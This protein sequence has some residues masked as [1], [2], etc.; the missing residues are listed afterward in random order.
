MKSFLAQGIIALLVC[1]GA[2]IGFWVWY[3]MIEAKS[4]SVAALEQQIQQD[5]DT[6]SRV[7]AARASLAE[8][9]QDEA[10]IRSYFISEVDV[11]SFNDALETQRHAPGATVKVVSVSRGGPG[12]Q[13]T[14]LF[15]LSIDGAFD[16]V[17]RT[18]GMIEYAP[19]AVTVSG[20]N[21]AHADTTGKTSL[22]HADLSLIVNTVS[23]SSTAGT[24]LATPSF[25]ATTSPLFIATST[26]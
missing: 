9:S 6:E 4:A 18:I 1:G 5:A 17:M 12:A 22:W 21:L 13:S 16:A 8:I 26:P 3:G 2:A 10:N 19:F 14:L 24:A 25:A 23:A 7:A 15:S 11:A 20:L